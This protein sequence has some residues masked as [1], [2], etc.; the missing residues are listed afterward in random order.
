MDSRDLELAQLRE[1][2]AALTTSRD[3]ERRARKQA[4]TELRPTTLEE[5]LKQCYKHLDQRFSV[6]ANPLFTTRGSVTS[7]SGKRCPRFLRP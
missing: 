3:E 7:L 4:E 5:L 2:P 1:Q 6:N